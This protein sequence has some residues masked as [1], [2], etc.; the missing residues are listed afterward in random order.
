M[1]LNPRIEEIS[2]I[3]LVGLHQKMSYANDSTKSLWGAFMPRRKEIL[4]AIENKF[5]SLQVYPADFF[6]SFDIKKEFTKW[7]GLEVQNENTIP[8][9]MSSFT[10]PAGKYAVFTHIGPDT[11]IFQQIYGRWIPHSAYELD[12][13]PHFELLDEHYKKGDPN[14]KEEIWIPIKLRN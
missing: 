11:S 5:Y 10:V 1:Q 12:D 2:L 8:E 9:G 13:R 6:R 3:K 7:A 14:S 4:N